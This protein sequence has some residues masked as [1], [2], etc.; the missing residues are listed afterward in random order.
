M[1][2]YNSWPLTSTHWGTYRVETQHGKVKALHG[3]EE[4]NDV[5]GIGSGI[6]DVLDAPSRIKTPVVRQS[7]LELGP[8]ANTQKRGAEPFVA[9][10]WETAEKLVAEELIRVKNNYGNAAIYGGSY[11]WASA[12]RFHHAQSQ[13]HRF[14]NCIGGYTR[15][16]DTYSYA[17]GEVIIPHVLGVFQELLLTTTSWPS[18]IKHSNLL[19]AFGGVPLK[20]GQSIPAGLAVIRNETIWQRRVKRGWSSSILARSAQ[21]WKI[22]PTPNGWPRDQ[23]RIARLCS[24]LRTPCMSKGFTTVSSLSAIRTD[25]INLCPI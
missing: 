23:V 21:I 16:V 14:L 18:I 17:A 1:P 25:S 3:F 2:N 24:R 13:I 9:V 7:W 8:G 5:S 6:V 22:L 12:G 11:G 15:S 19:V 4:D 20:N 10:S